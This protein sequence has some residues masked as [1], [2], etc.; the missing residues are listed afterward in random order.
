LVIG[1][2]G[3]VQRELNR[4]RVPVFSTFVAA[5]WVWCGWYFLPVQPAADGL[6]VGEGF[7]FI[8]HL[9][10]L[11]A[12][13]LRRIWVIKFGH[14]AVLVR[15]TCTVVEKR[16]GGG[17]H[18]CHRCGCLAGIVLRTAL[19]GPGRHAGACVWGGWTTCNCGCLSALN[20]R[21]GLVVVAARKKKAARDRTGILL[22]VVRAAVCHRC[23][24]CCLP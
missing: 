24:T 19:C 9:P 5:L 1:L 16:L 3:A 4:V 7:L 22:R 23:P 17:G 18:T 21:F 13:A 6:P 8:P 15:F 12:F 10:L 20:G 14:L 2:D 11:W